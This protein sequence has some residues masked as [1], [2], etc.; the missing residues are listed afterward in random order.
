[1]DP[2]VSGQLNNVK[3]KNYEINL[4]FLIIANK[5]NYFI[6]LQSW[7]GQHLKGNTSHFSK[8]IKG[9]SNLIVMKMSKYLP[10]RPLQ[11]KEVLTNIL[12]KY[13]EVLL[14]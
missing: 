11:C 1:M 8:E 14:L 13:S 10:V 9:K 5:L 7:G 12:V 3:Y 2:N 6:L 4:F